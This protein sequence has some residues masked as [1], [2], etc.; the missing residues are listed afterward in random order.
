MISLFQNSPKPIV[1][2]HQLKIPLLLRKAQ[3]VIFR[4]FE[5]LKTLLDQKPKST[6]LEEITPPRRLFVPQLPHPPFRSAKP[7]RFFWHPAYVPPSDGYSPSCL[8]AEAGEDA[9]AAVANST[10]ICSY[11]RRA[12][13]KQ[14]ILKQDQDGFVYLEL[15]DEFITDLAQL[16]QDRECEPVPLYQVEP[17]PAHIP[18]ILP[19]EWEQK[20]GW[21]AIKEL[22][23]SF[24]FEV[25]CL[26]ALKPRNWPGVDKVYFLEVKSPELEK[27]RERLL[28]PPRIRG[29]AFHMA[30]AIRKSAVEAPRETFRLNVSCFAA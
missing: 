10:S 26:R 5:V 1:E 11:A 21:G 8:M 2:L 12:L 7:A 20:K 15:P 9:S 30:I 29:H 17:S 4:A 16:I 24:S 3:L 13:S 27:A 6:V 22:Q 28:L 14:G 18:V 25:Q 23:E 19:H